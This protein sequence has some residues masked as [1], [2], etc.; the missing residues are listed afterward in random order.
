MVIGSAK[1]QGS[2]GCTPSPTRTTRRKVFCEAGAKNE[3]GEFRQ[4]LHVWGY[5]SNGSTYHPGVYPWPFASAE[6]DV[7]KLAAYM[8]ITKFKNWPGNWCQFYSHWNHRE[9]VRA[10]G[11]TLYWRLAPS[12]VVRERQLPHGSDDLRPHLIPEIFINAL[13]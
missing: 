7:E 13:T 11:A 10:D 4:W 5:D 3:L 8:Y 1:P 6:I 9:H 12:L 2:P